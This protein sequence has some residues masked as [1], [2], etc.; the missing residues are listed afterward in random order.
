MGANSNKKR[1]VPFKEQF[2]N[3]TPITTN[4]KLA[5]SEYKKGKN[6]VLHGFSGTGKTLSAMYLGLESLFKG[7]QSNI[8]IVR[9]AVPTQDIGFLKGSYEEKIAPYEEPYDSICDF[10]F[11]TKNNYDELKERGYVT[12]MPVSFIRGITFD[13]SVII[14]D[15]Y[16]NCNYH[17]LSSVMT[18]MGNNSRIIFSG[19]YRQTDL[20]NN[21]DK[22]GIL[23]FN[24]VLAHMDEFST[25]EFNA[26]DIVRS[27]VVKNFIVTEQKLVDSGK[28][29]I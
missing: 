11:K 26:Q 8:I 27:Q 29:I 16:Q 20:H 22:K 3:I 25:I 10:L 7:E 13:D 12:F 1:N 2:K 19:D 9:S 5:F 15:E 6:L 18:R 28:I 17:Q 23:Y 14:V 21:K 4:Q 24:E